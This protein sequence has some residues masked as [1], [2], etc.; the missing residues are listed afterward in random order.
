VGPVDILILIVLGIGLIIGFVKGF[1]RQLAAL[2]GLVGGGIAAYFMYGWG[3][4][5]LVPLLGISI[6]NWVA[7]LVL[8]IITFGI[9]SFLFTLLGRAMKKTLKAVNLG[10]I[11]RLMGSIVGLAKSLVLVLLVMMLLMITPLR[12]GIAAESEVE[13]VLGVVSGIAGSLLDHLLGSAPRDQFLNQLEFWGFDK[14][15]CDRILQDPELIFELARSP[16]FFKKPSFGSGE[17]TSKQLKDRFQT[18]RQRIMEVIEDTE[19]TAR[20]KAD[21][22]LEFLHDVPKQL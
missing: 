2:A 10:G 11:D 17:Q 13:P 15:C 6:P 14:K 7:G 12:S 3:H 8:A 18:T 22:I 4:L 1:V 20:Q 5:N 21:C 9:V 19:M 16:G